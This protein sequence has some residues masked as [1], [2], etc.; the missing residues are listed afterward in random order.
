MLSSIIGG[1][2][3]LAVSNR[4][5]SSGFL[6]PYPIDQIYRVGRRKHWSY[7]K[8]VKEK[9]SQY[10]ETNSSEYLELLKLM[11]DFMSQDVNLLHADSVTLGNLQQKLDDLNFAFRHVDNYMRGLTVSERREIWTTYIDSAIPRIERDKRAFIKHVEKKEVWS[12]IE[13]LMLSYIQVY[14][15]FFKSLNADLKRCEDVDV[16]K[17]LRTISMFILVYQPVIFAYEGI[18]VTKDLVS[19]RLS[20]MFIMFKSPPLGV[21]TPVEVN[22][23]E[24]MAKVP[25]EVHP[26]EGAS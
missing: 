1:I 14:V 5:L 19:R 4:H 7:A 20:E 25:F 13:P 21:P 26:E 22:I 9:L 24:S 18:D 10:A 8:L 23:L 12:D 17:T 11:I 16:D 6:N 3:N 2:G 15:M